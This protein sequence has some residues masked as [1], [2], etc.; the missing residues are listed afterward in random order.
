MDEAVGVGIQVVLHTEPLRTL[1]TCKD[2]CGIFSGWIVL[3][4]GLAVVLC[5]LHTHFKVKAPTLNCNAQNFQSLQ[6]LR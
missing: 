3:C 2:S 5:V 4:N 1:G 6:N